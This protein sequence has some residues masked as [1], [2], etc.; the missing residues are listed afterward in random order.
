MSNLQTAR[1]QSIPVGVSHFLFFSLFFLPLQPSHFCLSPSG[2]NS[3]KQWHDEHI[4]ALNYD[5]PC[6]LV[7]DLTRVSSS[8]DQSTSA[9]DRWKCP[10]LFFSP[11]L[12]AFIPWSFCKWTGLIN[13]NA[14]VSLT[15]W[16]VFMKHTFPRASFTSPWLSWYAGS[17]IEY[18]LASSP[19]NG[20]RQSGTLINDSLI[21]SRSRSLDLPH[22]FEL[23]GSHA[24]PAGWQC[25]DDPSPNMW[26]FPAIGSPWLASR[27]TGK[28][29]SNQ[30]TKPWKMPPNTCR[31]N[32]DC[33]LNSGG[34]STSDGL[35]CSSTTS[36]KTFLK[37]G[38][39]FLTHSPNRNFTLWWSKWLYHRSYLQ[40]LLN[41]LKNS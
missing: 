37:N 24:R 30:S 12:C 13:Y 5:L 26:F 23:T 16:L 39:N 40:T 20:L 25:N 8:S 41:H 7:S 2:K 35:M 28:S 31:N 19:S 22:L 14:L 3:L 11:L 17:D 33:C 10:C 1:W 9:A 32:L 27:W 38:M 34:C 15:N 21:S 6:W 36:W 29:K 18:T 4:K